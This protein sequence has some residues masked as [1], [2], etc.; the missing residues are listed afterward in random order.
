MKK[1]LKKFL[2]KFN[3]HLKKKENYNPDKVLKCYEISPS[4]LKNQ[5]R[6]INPFERVFKEFYQQSEKNIYHKNQIY[7]KENY[8]KL[9]KHYYIYKNQLKKFGTTFGISEKHFDY[10][11]EYRNG[12]SIN[13]ICFKKEGNFLKE[14]PEFNKYLKDKN[15][16]M[17]PKDWKVIIKF[18]ILFSMF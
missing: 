3:P 14:N 18:S 8:E 9:M 4:L 12:H 16:L 10:E 5:L 2:I 7:T 1:Q 15:V 13:V 6:F 11:D 17:I